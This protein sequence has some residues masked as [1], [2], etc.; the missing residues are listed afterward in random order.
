[1]GFEFLDL[2]APLL[3]EDCAASSILVKAFKI[4][5]KPVA[6]LTR[7]GASQGSTLRSVRVATGSVHRIPADAIVDIPLAAGIVGGVS[8][9]M[10]NSLEDAV[11]ARFGP[12][13]RIRESSSTA[14]G[15]IHYAAKVDLGG[16]EGACKLVLIVV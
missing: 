13:V 6:S 7:C 1:M 9:R 8:L 5:S 14:C 15:T 16:L 2:L 10:A 11:A 12:H 3:R 4:L